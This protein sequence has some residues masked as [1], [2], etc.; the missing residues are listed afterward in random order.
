MAKINDFTIVSELNDEFSLRVFMESGQKVAQVNNVSHDFLREAMPT[1]RLGIRTPGL[2]P[3]PS[4]FK[5]NPVPDGYSIALSHKYT[6]GSM[7]LKMILNKQSR[8]RY[9]A[10]LLALFGNNEN[11]RE[12]LTVMLL[13]TKFTDEL[14]YLSEQLDI[15]RMSV[16]TWDSVAIDNK[17]G[18]VKFNDVRNSPCS[19]SSALRNGCLADGYVPHPNIWFR[20][21]KNK[22]LFTKI[23]ACEMFPNLA[24]KILASIPK[25]PKGGKV[26]RIV[27]IR[28]QILF[29][30]LRNAYGLKYE[31]IIVDKQLDLNTY[32]VLS[33]L[34]AI[35]TAAAG[36]GGRVSIT[37][38]RGVDP[39]LDVKLRFSLWYRNVRSRILTLQGNYGVAGDAWLMDKLLTS[40]AVVMNAGDK[41]ESEL[42]TS[43]V[44]AAVDEN[45]L[46]E[47]LE[48]WVSKRNINMY[49][50]DTNTL[51]A[52]N[53]PASTLRSIEDGIDDIV[54]SLSDKDNIVK[55]LKELVRLQESSISGKAFDPATTTNYTNIQYN[56]NGLVTA[57]LIP[58]ITNR[59]QLL[60][61]IYRMSTYREN[62]FIYDTMGIVNRC[63]R[64]ISSHVSS[65]EY[66]VGI[67]KKWEEL[68]DIALD[69]VSHNGSGYFPSEM[70]Y[71][72]ALAR[73]LVTDWQH[74]CRINA[75]KSR[76]EL[77][78]MSVL[79]DNPFADIENSVCQEIDEY[80]SGYARWRE[81]RFK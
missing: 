25:Y 34:C 68:R 11:T 14:R 5:E 42:L 64:T 19:W 40:L 43:C 61:Y 39:D 10:L 29:N 67:L 20:D 76:D 37:D 51:N 15:S 9:F 27:D 35:L 1:S 24:P 65:Y 63:S 16:R 71:W 23:S 17:P 4:K 45:D 46:Q 7:C 3:W 70:L 36:L 69:Q 6:F 72:S 59:F 53:V 12:L 22:S 73:V 79:T 31:D 66:S 49:L 26:D 2:A 52:V 8:H 47:T 60:D 48:G 13:R 50:G 74:F 62:E 32:E 78:E 56:N 30:M 21:V 33:S 55:C 77:F 44:R 81:N 80:K 58:M 41:Q 57:S 38:I 28:T 54:Q 18:S 75:G